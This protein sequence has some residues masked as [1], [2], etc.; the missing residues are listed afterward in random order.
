M[1]LLLI[2]LLLGSDEVKR[3][4]DVLL[5]NLNAQK[6]Y[7]Y[8]LYPTV[9]KKYKPDYA[10]PMTLTT[11]YHSTTTTTGTQTSTST[12]TAGPPKLKWTRYYVVSPK[13]CMYAMVLELT[14]SRYRLDPAEHLQEKRRAGQ[15]TSEMI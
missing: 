1:F 15:E 12:T 14:R 7:A 3:Y 13:I 2:A 6:D 8:S 9:I 5:A 11:T 10:T 4:S